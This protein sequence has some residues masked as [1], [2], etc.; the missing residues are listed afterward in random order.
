MRTFRTLLL[1]ACALSLTSCATIQRAQSTVGQAVDMLHS[2]TATVNTVLDR[3]APL[4]NTQVDEN[5]IRGAYTTFDNG[6]TL[7]HNLHLTRNSPTAMRVRAGIDIVKRTLRVAYNAQRI[8]NA[9]TVRQA[10]TEARTALVGLTTNV[11]GSR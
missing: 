8:G 9:A 2:V 1:G 4:A 10:L 3:P 11:Q 6:L 5:L 7:I